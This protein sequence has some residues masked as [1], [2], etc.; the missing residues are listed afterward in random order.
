[1]RDAL[2]LLDQA[3]SFGSDRVTME[4]ALT[5]T[6]AVSQSFLTKIVKSHP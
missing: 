3:I 4:D 2:S 5:V 1:M 6:G